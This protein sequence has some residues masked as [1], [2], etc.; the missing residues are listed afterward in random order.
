MSAQCG[1][2]YL[3]RVCFREISFQRKWNIFNSVSGQSFIT[4]YMKY[5][6]MKFFAGVIS[7][8]SFW[9]KWSFIS[10]DVC[11]NYPETRSFKQK[12]LRIRIFHKNEDSRSRD[13]NKNEFRYVL[14]AMKTNVNRIFFMAKGNLILGL[15]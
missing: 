11:E 10:G 7:L 12:H 9:E 13:Q 15:K 14:S 6:E 5:L 1:S 4:V 3:L 2:F 8:Q